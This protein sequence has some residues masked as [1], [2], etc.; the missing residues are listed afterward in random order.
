MIKIDNVILLKGHLKDFEYLEE[1]G[2]A[3]GVGG[4]WITGT[5]SSIPFTAAPF[6]L[7][8]KLRLLSQGALDYKDIK[9]YTKYDLVEVGDKDIKR[10]DKNETFRLYDVKPYEEIADLKVYILKRIVGES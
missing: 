5:I 4:V 2:G 1:T 7:G 6:P 8:E 9:I 3:Y 10:L